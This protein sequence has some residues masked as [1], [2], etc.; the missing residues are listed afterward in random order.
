[1]FRDQ[2]S[3]QVRE[4]SG[5]VFGQPSGNEALENG[6]WVSA[7]RLRFL[8]RSGFEAGILRGSGKMPRTAGT[9]GSRAPGPIFVPLLLIV[10]THF[11]FLHF[12]LFVSYCGSSFDSKKIFLFLLFLLSS[13]CLCSSCV[14]FT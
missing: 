1:M 3:Q 9:K 2:L 11:L 7:V 14:S 10:L 8:G 13:S 12:P 5:V 4:T 6:F